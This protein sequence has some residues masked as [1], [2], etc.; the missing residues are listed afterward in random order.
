MAQLPMSILCARRRRSLRLRGN[1]TCVVCVPGV[2]EGVVGEAD[3]VNESLARPLWRF[4]PRALPVRFRNQ[5]IGTS[6]AVADIR[7]ED[8]RFGA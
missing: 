2:K 5:F 7:K 6:G 1:A 4:G 3:R 8:L